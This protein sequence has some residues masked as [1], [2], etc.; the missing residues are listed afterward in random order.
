MTSSSRGDAAT[1]TSP[2]GTRI[3]LKVRGAGAAVV[4]VDGALCYSGMG[5]GDALA[6]GLGSHFRVHQYDRRGRGL[7]SDVKP[8]SVERE[9]EDLDAVVD[10]AGGSVRLWGISSGALLALKYAARHPGKV[11]KVSIYEAPCIVD[12]GHAPTAG[13]WAL[14]AEAVSHGARGKAVRTF[15]K[16]VGMPGIAVALM[17]ILPPWRKLK[18]VA[19]TLPYDGEIVQPYQ[20]GQPLDR[21]EW[22]SLTLP[23]QV[24][25]GASS[26]GWMQTGN[27]A[28]CAALAS[29]EWL[30]LKGQAHDVKAS[31]LAPVLVE[32]FGTSAAVPTAGIG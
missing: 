7:S 21:S 1:A 23:V 11:D 26:P 25:V 9:I 14:V 6:S 30:V 13:D 24:V 20:L 17:S 22:E 10:A 15:L 27:R 19:H 3:A 5:P 18:A 28:L 16:S 31:V 32:F 8:Y 12:G 4:L 29:G 2:D